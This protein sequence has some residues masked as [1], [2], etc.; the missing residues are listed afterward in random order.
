MT[1]LP[2]RRRRNT[3]IALC[4]G[5]IAAIFVPTLVY[6]GANA[7][8]NSKAGRNAL[9]NAPLEQS[10]PQTPTAMLATVSDTNELMSVT[11]LVLAPDADESAAVY[12][13]R[14]GSIVSV[15][16]NVDSGSGDQL[17]SLHDAYA[18]GG[19]DELLADLESAVNLTIDFTAV[20][21]RDEL[22][23][24]L[25]GLPSI[26]ADLPT[27]V[28]GP[29]E[30]V[31]LA[32]G[33]NNLTATQVAQI[34]TS[35]SPTQ[36]EHLRQADLEAIWSGVAAAIGKGREGLTLSAASPTTFAEMSARLMSSSVASRGLVARPLEADRNPEGLD[37]EALDRP[38]TI[39]V[40]AS[41]A[42]AQM[43]R[44]ASG[45]TFRL[46]AP[47]G[48]DQQVR[49]TIGVLLS[50]GGNVVSVDL[51]ADANADTKFLIYD[52]S[53][54]SVE[55]TENP[56]FGTIKVDTPPIRLGSIDET[57]QLGTTY[58]KGV[59]LS[60]PDASSTSTSTSVAPTETTA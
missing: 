27:D 16:I 35:K 2:G 39:L 49:K 38:D 45:L 18:L 56:I 36:R 23:A 51:N 54:A 8:S 53:L 40:F 24:F 50:F 43:S 17:L 60:A 29:D 44:P 31:V 58:L 37:V 46:E 57:I 26:Q 20:M 4:A 28:L 12:D 32:K 41:I 59:D 11:V 48:Y 15:P 3:V 7:I 10:F 1:S 6:V 21:K 47:P 52:A 33:P 14:G 34:L 13:Q 55:P 5:L 42:P 9:A 25:T 30:A 22:A 19:P